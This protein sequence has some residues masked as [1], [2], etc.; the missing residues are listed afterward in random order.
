VVRWFP[1]CADDVEGLRTIFSAYTDPQAGPAPPRPGGPPPLLARGGDRRHRRAGAGER[2]DHILVDE[3]QDTNLVQADI[4]R[5]M[6]A[7]DIAITVV[8]DDAQAIYSFRAATVR[9]ILDFPLHFPGTTDHHPGAELPLDHAHPGA[10]Q[11]RDRRRR[12]RA[13]PNSCGP[14]NRRRRPS[15]PG[16]LPRPA[17]PGHG[18]QPDHPRPLRVGHSAARTRPCSSAPATT[19]TCSKSSSV[20]G[21]SP[22]SSTADC[23]SW[24]RPTCATSWPCSASSRTRGTRWP[25]CGCCSWPTGWGRHR[26]SRRSSTHLGVRHPGRG[27]PDPLTVSVPRRQSCGVAPAGRRPRL[28]PPPSAPAGTR[29]VGRA[30]RSTA[31]RALE[32][33]VRRRYDHPEARLA[34]FDAL[35]R[36]AA[37]A[38][39]RRAQLVADLTLDPPTSTGDLAGHAVTRRRLAHPVHRALGQGRR[40]GRRPRHPR[41]RRRLPLGPGHRER[42]GRGRG[43]APLLRGPHP[44][45]ASPAHLRPAPL[46]PRRPGRADRQ[47]QLRP[48]HAGSC[49]PSWTTCS[50][51]GPSGAADD[52]DLPASPLPLTTVVDAELSSLW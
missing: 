5:A 8:G 49:L 37:D 12:A 9:N 25:G 24:R 6:A 40:V 46:P 36:I 14:T 11:R 44:G 52:L 42:R 1:W 38:P 33:M 34:D 45:P 2:F 51:T 19:A 30:P 31:P 35:A 16:H 29:P 27:G 28:W 48:A 22:S 23:A 21:G 32:P 15:H 10:G 47:A 3:Y 13:C 50:T 18:R 7:H 43:A 39:R 41:R 26:R 17:G 4:L 20:G